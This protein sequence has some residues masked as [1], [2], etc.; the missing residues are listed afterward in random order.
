[1]AIK[2][3]FIGVC[4]IKK[5]IDGNLTHKAFLKKLISPQNYSSRFQLKVITIIYLTHPK[6]LELNRLA[7]CSLA[8]LCELLLL[9]LASMFEKMLPLSGCNSWCKFVENEWSQPP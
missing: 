7:C 6:C 9:L 1:M 3:F 5:Y 2:E 8:K 4:L